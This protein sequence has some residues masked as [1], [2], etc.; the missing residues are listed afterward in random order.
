MSPSFTFP[1]G[2]GQPTSTLGKRSTSSQSSHLRI[3]SCPILN[4]TGPG[5]RTKEPCSTSTGEK[6][7]FP[8]VLLR[9]LGI[10]VMSLQNTALLNSVGE[11]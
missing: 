2:K 3:W 9:G 10:K 11:P 7:S 8:P 6:S 5:G 1:L 4:P